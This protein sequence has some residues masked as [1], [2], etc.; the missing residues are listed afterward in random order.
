MITWGTYR[1]FPHHLFKVWWNRFGFPGLTIIFRRWELRAGWIPVN[2]ID[3][4]IFL[5]AVLLAW[6]LFLVIGYFF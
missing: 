2:W 5:G 4:L 3:N 1:R 6:G